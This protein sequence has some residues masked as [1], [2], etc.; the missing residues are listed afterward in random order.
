MASRQ[1]RKDACSSRKIRTSAADG[2]NQQALRWRPGVR[3]IRPGAGRCSRRATPGFQAVPAALRPPCARS[4]SVDVGLDVDAAGP[5]VR[6]MRFG[7]GLHADVGDVGQADPLPAGGIDGQVLDAG[8]A[9]PGLRRAPDLD[10]VGPAVPVDVADFLAGHERRGRAPDVTGLQPV[11]LR[12]CQVHLDVDL[13]DVDLQGDMR[14][15][16]PLDPA[17]DAS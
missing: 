8:D 6:S 7:V 2:E 3:C 16:G 4:P 1:L 10:V 13:R 9:G 5:F 11:L 12:R 17:Q 14:D 15:P